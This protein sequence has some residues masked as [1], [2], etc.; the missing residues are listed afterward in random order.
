MWNSFF[1]V[2]GTNGTTLLASCSQAEPCKAAYLQL[3]LTPT[4]SVYLENIWGWAA[5]HDIDN[6]PYLVTNVSV[7]RGLLVESRQAT[8]LHGISFQHNAVYQIYVRQAVSIFLG[9]HETENP[10]WQ[11]IGSP[12]S[13]WAPSGWAV[14]TS[15]ADPG[16]GSCNPLNG[17]CYM[18]W[19]LYVAR[20]SN[21]YIYNSNMNSYKANGYTCTND[22]QLN[23]AYLSWNLGIHW[24]GI[25]TRYTYNMIVAAN[26][27]TQT[28]DKNAGQSLGLANGGAIGAWLVFSYTV[29]PLTLPASAANFTQGGWREME[30]KLTLDQSSTTLS[31]YLSGRR[32]Y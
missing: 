24:F 16:F 32:F 17:S 23:G 5:D 18:A 26:Q 27:T 28:K 8:W 10:N 9:L 15:L 19:H 29:G 2:G 1:R 13:Y 30:M 14:N 20:S 12:A 6:R 4:S 3:H 31:T 11:G 22:C 7:A 21:V 25:N